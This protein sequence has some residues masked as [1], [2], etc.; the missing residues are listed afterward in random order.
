M[1]RD[2]RQSDLK[3]VSGEIYSNKSYA[4][5]ISAWFMKA[6]AAQYAARRRLSEQC[7][8]ISD[9]VSS[10]YSYTHTVFHD[11]QSFKEMA[12]SVHVLQ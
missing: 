10:P 7:R 3:C 11:C 9:R 6:L 8:Y 2:D 5:S 4:T 1:F 12:Y